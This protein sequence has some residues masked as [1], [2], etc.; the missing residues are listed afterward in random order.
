MTGQNRIRRTIDVVTPAN[1]LLRAVSLRRFVSKASRIPARSRDGWIRVLRVGFFVIATHGAVVTAEESTLAEFLRMVESTRG[2]PIELPSDPRPLPR[3]GRTSEPM[4]ATWREPLEPSS[5]RDQAVTIDVNRPAS[6]LQP[7]PNILAKDLE[8]STA[9]APP[10]ESL[11]PPEVVAT[12]AMPPPT[13]PGNSLAIADPDWMWWRASTDGFLLD[14]S[15]WLQFD[16]PTILNDAIAWSPRVAAVSRQTSIAFEQIVQQDAVFDSSV[17][18]DAGI[19]RVN[20]PVGNT[21]TTGGPPRLI[22]DSFTSSAGIRK[23]TRNGGV[24][25]LSQELGTLTSNSTFFDPLRQGNSRLSL[26]ITQPLLATGGRAYNTRLITQASIDSRIAWSQLRAEIEEH[27]V[28]TFNAFWRLYERRCHLVQQN[29]LIARGQDI[30][31]MVEARGDFD[32]GPLQRLKIQR[33]LSDQMDRLTTLETDVRQG[34][35]R[36]RTLVG[37]DDEITQV[38]DAELIP[39]ANPILPHQSIDLRDAVIR[40]LENRPDIRAATEQL[41]AAGLSVNVTR[42][43]LKPRLDAVLDAYLAGLNGQNDFFRSF[44]DQFSTG[45]PGLTA[46]LQYELPWGR[47]AAKSRHREARYRYQQRSEELRQTLIDARGEIESAIINVNAMMALRDRREQT[48]IAAMKEESIQL[49]RWKT[50]G[51]DGVQMALVLED[52][53]ETQ[54]RRTAAE[55][56]FVTTAVD[57]VLALVTLQRAMGTLLM[58][59]NVTPIRPGRTS[60]IEVIRDAPIEAIQDSIEINE[61]IYLPDSVSEIQ[62]PGKP[63]IDHSPLIESDA[64]AAELP[65]STFLKVNEPPMETQP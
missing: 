14:S 30:G 12:P 1:R 27:L 11:P 17:L 43:E 21:L 40:G 50:L 64:D 13:T 62:S 19:G 59:E 15:H 38:R 34:Q 26:S 7:V 41:S 29:A 10:P 28:Q 3:P 20:D 5:A 33:R 55:Q 49:Q 2:A 46:T 35:I 6:K 45:G 56:A 57:H 54:S 16:L 61:E 48:L 65:L 9:V 31:R 37:G 36:L 23:R 51:T 58:K 18:I 8:P 60:Q 42:N 52:L 39:L 53:L 47:R 63:L 44:G 22:Q 4:S 24:I 25:D 32:S